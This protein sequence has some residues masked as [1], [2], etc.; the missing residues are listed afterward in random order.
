MKILIDETYRKTDEAHYCFVVA[1]VIASDDA[2]DSFRNWHKESFLPD[3]LRFKHKKKVHFTDEDSGTKQH[4]VEIVKSLEITA[5]IY[6]WYG[7]GPI[8]AAEI[9]QWS[10]DY[11]K[12]TDQYSEFFIEQSSSQYNHLASDRINIVASSDYPEIGIADIFAGVCA[13]KFLDQQKG[14]A[15]DRL[16]SFLRPRIRLILKREYDGRILKTTRAGIDR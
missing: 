13:A 1:H 5:K 12:Q 3:S 9:I 8:N 15:S 6:M 7:T 16:Y 2:I 4:L 11:Q 10:L 14:Q